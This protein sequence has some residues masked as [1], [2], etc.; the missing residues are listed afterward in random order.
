M[1]VV[2][3][4]LH[5][6]VYAARVRQRLPHQCPAFVG[7]PASGGLGGRHDPDVD[8]GGEGTSGR[9]G[10]CRTWAALRAVKPRA[11]S[12]ISLCTLT[13]FAA[14]TRSLDRGLSTLELVRSIPSSTHLAYRKYTT[15][16]VRAATSTFA[17]ML[18]LTSLHIKFDMQEKGVQA[19][20]HTLHT[21]L[22]LV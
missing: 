14:P 4:R 11:A 18:C 7:Q 3:G 15:S 10:T 12:S 17:R 8:G 13:R 19:E 22:P 5:P 6:A 9:Y 21:F 1:L 16:V 20:A 2:R